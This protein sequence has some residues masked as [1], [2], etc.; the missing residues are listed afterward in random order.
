[1]LSGSLRVS[2]SL[3]TNLFWLISPHHQSKMRT[4][5]VKLDRPQ[6]ENKK[7]SIAE[8]QLKTVNPFAHARNPRQLW[9][10]RKKTYWAS[11]GEQTKLIK[12][13]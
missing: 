11:T 5:K 10:A 4:P 12:S 8:R 2:S 6:A 9:S 3:T 1:M 13:F 7:L